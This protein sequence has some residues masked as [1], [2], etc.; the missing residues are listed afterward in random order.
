MALPEDF[1]QLIIG[2]VLLAWTA[3]LLL[4]W[5]LRAQGMRRFERLEASS[6][7]EMLGELATAY[8]R[9]QA[10][11]II[12]PVEYLPFVFERIR[13]VVDRGFGDRQVL[14]LLAQVDFHRPYETR[15]AVF[16]V[17][18]A[19][20]T[21][22]LQLRWARDDGGRLRLWVTAS[23]EIVRALRELKKTI[24]RLPGHIEQRELFADLRAIQKGDGK[25]PTGTKPKGS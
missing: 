2:A 4:M 20:R 1:P 25:R 5:L 24:P 14:A 19:G 3:G 17:E 7:D 8:E 13:E 18:V 21:V 16:P 9:R 10:I 11:S 15:Q 22:D 23:S 12:T 6:S